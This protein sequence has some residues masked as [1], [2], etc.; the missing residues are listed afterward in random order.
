MRRALP[1][2]LLVAACAAP[3]K[4]ER[5]QVRA[6]EVRLPENARA[7]M[8]VTWRIEQAEPEPDD[9]VEETVACVARD[10]RAVTM[11]WRTTLRDGSKRVVAARFRPDGTRL[12]AWRGP[13]A[14]IAHPLEVLPDEDPAVLREEAGHMGKP[15]RISP[16]DLK[17]EDAHGKEVLQTPAGRI[18]CLRWTMS[19]SF[20]VTSMEVGLWVAEKPL[21]LSS[22]VRYQMT[23]RPGD[24]RYLQTLSVY[25]TNDPGPTLEIP[26]ED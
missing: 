20:L 2:L 9:V 10:E 5:D 19:S 15:R 12:G 14:G 3:R 4:G 6:G 22:L 26:S 8:F 21:P 16:D 25:G 13:P 11:E 18:P 17:V 24:Y 7:G 23:M 1:L